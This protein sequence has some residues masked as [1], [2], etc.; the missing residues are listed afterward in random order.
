MSPNPTL[1]AVDRCL[2]VSES[3]RDIELTRRAVQDSGVD[4]LAAFS[5]VNK[6]LVVPALWTTLSRPALCEFIPKDVRDYLAL[7]H[8]RN[9]A[10]NARIRVQC[11]GVGSILAR[12][13]LQAVL[14]KGAA[15]LFDDHAAP[16]SDRMMRDIDLVVAADDFE[17]AVRALA[18]SGYR[19][20]SGVLTEHGHIHHTLMECQAAEA[21]VEIHRDLFGCA[22]LLPTKEVIASAREVAS[23]LLLPGSRHR[24]VHNVIHAQ[25]ANGDFVGGVFNLRDGLDLAR[26]VADSGPEFDWTVVAVEARDRGYFHQLSGALHSAHRIL[27]SPLPPPFAGDRLGRLHALRCVQQRRWP[28]ISKPLELLG[29]LTRALAWERDAYPLGLATRRSL[30]AQALVNMRRARRSMAALGRKLPWLRGIPA[31]DPEWSALKVDAS[32]A[33]RQ[34][35]R[36]DEAVA[37]Y[38][39]KLAVT[40]DDPAA[41]LKLGLSLRSLQ[42][43]EEALTWLRKASDLRPDHADSARELGDVLAAL[44]HNDEAIAAYRRAL[45]AKPDNLA[46]LLSLGGSLHEARR[47]EEATEAYE[48]AVAIDSKRSDAWNCLGTAF[49]GVKRYEDALAA[50]QK[51][52]AEEPGSAAAYCNMTLALIGLDRL[53]EAIEASRK[54]LFIEAGS[55]VATF[56]LGCAL[57]SRG[58]FR[59]GWPAYEYRFVMGGNRWLRAEA[60]AA[61]WT[62]EPLAGKSI[63]VLGE[64]GNGDQIQFSRYLPALSDLGAS[65]SYLAP[66]RLHRLFGTLRGSIAFLTE[67]PPDARFDFQCPLM[68]LPGRFDDLGLP[69]PTTTPYLAAEPDRIVRWKGRI[70]DGGFKVGVAWRGNHNDGDA[71]RSF[72]LDALQTLAAIPGVRLISLQLKDGIEELKSLPAGMRVEVLD[73]DFDAGEHGFL[74]SAAVLGAVDLVISCDTSI[75]HLAGALGRPVWI[76]L[77]RDPEWRWQR[78]RDDSIWYQTARLFRQQTLG[79]WG[80]V[81]ARMTAEIAQLLDAA[82][83]TDRDRQVIEQPV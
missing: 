33:Q 71:W 25:I 81:F 72:R 38:H 52:L 44:K 73:D 10:R 9:A 83:C 37:R 61:P 79:D 56:N 59:D 6:H 62:G 74:D 78:Q 47:F 5:L 15:W 55:A 11:L 64:Q 43:N 58:D 20:A 82:K 14:L 45:S 2:S 18:A 69:T 65:V 57:L 75:A 7:L 27:G 30:R 42:R 35:E 46:V 23:G 17:A 31:I 40:P 80:S 29:P 36:V 41:C 60:R 22:D 77:N 24:I 19:D 32:I 26:L 34:L 48:K 49:L 63:L 8:S 4:W 13:G 67:I 70:G 39:D 66:Q 21:G 51:A 28:R 16:V 76:A 54:A 12:A 68:S 50:F 3:P 53:D 1:V